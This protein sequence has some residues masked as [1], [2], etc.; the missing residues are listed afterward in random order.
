[1]HLRRYTNI[2]T[3]GDVQRG[4]TLAH[5][6]SASIEYAIHGKFSRAEDDAN[7]CFGYYYIPLKKL[8]ESFKDAAAVEL[9]ELIDTFEKELVEA[10]KEAFLACSVDSTVVPGDDDDE[11]SD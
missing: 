9:E 5:A 2:A 4:N 10:R 7:G 1:M 3:M 11:A 6:R 8:Y